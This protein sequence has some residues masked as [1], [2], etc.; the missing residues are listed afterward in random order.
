[1]D[2]G[3]LLQRRG[4]GQQGA[5]QAAAGGAG[6]PGGGGEDE[7]TLRRNREAFDL[8][9][10]LPDVR[11]D[12]SHVDT[13]TTVLGQRIPL[14]FALSPIGAPRMFHHQGELA[15]A[16]AARHAGIPY[17]ISTLVTTAV[18]DVA[19]QTDTPLWVPTLRMGRPG[20]D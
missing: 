6:V 20:R 15:V 11:R 5:A 10:F 16:R 3:P 1:M 17:G 19:A 12:V 8:L 9:E 13:S 7:Y 14:P 4:R 18:E 2:A